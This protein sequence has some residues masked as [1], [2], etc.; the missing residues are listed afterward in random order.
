VYA[1]LSGLHAPPKSG[2]FYFAVTWFLI[3]CRGKV[4]SS[5]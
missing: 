4:R 2:T 3:S 5:Y 1:H